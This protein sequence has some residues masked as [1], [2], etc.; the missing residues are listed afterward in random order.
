MVL[1]FLKILW[2]G[3]FVPRSE[4]LFTSSATL[5]C[6]TRNIS[7]FSMLVYYNTNGF[8]LRSSSLMHW[9]V[10]FVISEDFKVFLSITSSF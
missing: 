2:W 3:F 8:F 10:H 1:T 7:T 6:K 4:R 9:S 5:S